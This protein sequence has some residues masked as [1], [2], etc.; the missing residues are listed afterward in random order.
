MEVSKAVAIWLENLP[1]EVVEQLVE[2]GAVSD[3]DQRGPTGI[4][5]EGTRRRIDD[6][7]YCVF[8]DAQLHFLDRR[9][10]EVVREDVAVC[11][12]EGERRGALPV[13]PSRAVP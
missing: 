6:Q 9:S 8:P 2:G 5:L 10:V 12:A 1:T 11:R 13:R 7:H 3:L 4:R